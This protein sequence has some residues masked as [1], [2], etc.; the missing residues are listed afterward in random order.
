M[1]HPIGGIKIV[2]YLKK[3]NEEA[4]EEIDDTR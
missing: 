3:M 4:E 2:E 1:F